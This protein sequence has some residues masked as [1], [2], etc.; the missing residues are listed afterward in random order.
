MCIFKIPTPD[1]VVKDPVSASVVFPSKEFA[2]V[3]D[4]SGKLYLINTGE[5]GNATNQ[6]WSDH[7]LLELTNIQDSF[8]FV[9]ATKDAAKSIVHCILMTVE[10]EA[11]VSGKSIVT[12]HWLQIKE[13]SQI[14]QAAV[15]SLVESVKRFKG[16]SVPVYCCISPNFSELIVAGEGRFQ[17]LQENGLG[18]R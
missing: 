16:T 17:L 18:K 1:K 9:Y 11:G 5:R 3:N 12:L 4:G 13:Q 6:N 2:L 8:Y 15:D 14:S 10:D 7:K